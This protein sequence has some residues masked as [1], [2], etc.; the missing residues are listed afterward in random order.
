VF[1]KVPWSVCVRRKVK[2][3]RKDSAG[4]DVYVRISTYNI[5]IK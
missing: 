4:G 1:I 2:K 5:N 3:K